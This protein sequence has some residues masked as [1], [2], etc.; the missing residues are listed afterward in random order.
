MNY[1]TLISLPSFFSVF[2]IDIPLYHPFHHRLSVGALMTSTTTLHG[3]HRAQLQSSTPVELLVADML[4][5]V[6]VLLAPRT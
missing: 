3:A 1:K 5:K 6:S 2:F 4:A